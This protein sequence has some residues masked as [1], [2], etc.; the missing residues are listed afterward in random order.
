MLEAVT[1]FNST[2]ATCAGASHSPEENRAITPREAALIQ[3]FARRY[4]FAGALGAVATQIG[5]AV[6]IALL[7]AWT[8]SFREAIRGA[9]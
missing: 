3:T 9:V 8:P 5:N 2:T 6:P 4:R 1:N 7:R